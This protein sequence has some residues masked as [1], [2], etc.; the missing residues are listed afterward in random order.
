[1]RREDWSAIAHRDLEPMG[2]YD[3]GHVD[4]AL[5]RLDGLDGRRVIDL[6]CGTGSVLAHLAGGS[7][8]TGVGVDIRPIA[9]KIGGIELVKAD[10]GTFEPPGEAFDL[11]L[12]IGSVV[13]PERLAGVVRLAA[14]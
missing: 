1:M 2:P 11:A 13:G 8:M 4:L 9:R 7:G 6:G 3:M 14:E 12:S 5:D 10:A